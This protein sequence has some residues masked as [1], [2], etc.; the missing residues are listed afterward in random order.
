M[1]KWGRGDYGVFGDGNNKSLFAPKKNSFFSKMQSEG[2]DIVKIKSANNYSMALMSN[3]FDFVI[4][5]I[6]REW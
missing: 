3:F 5:K 4:R 6:N 2:F 1:Y